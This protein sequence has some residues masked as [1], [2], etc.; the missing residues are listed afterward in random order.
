MPPWTN[1]FMKG[2]T[3]IMFRIGSP[4]LQE[5]QL[6]TN[7]ATLVLEAKK[8]KAVTSI[9]LRVFEKEML[10]HLVLTAITVYVHPQYMGLQANKSPKNS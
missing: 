10:L 6:N 8:W 3:T 2:A 5:Y 1:E 4:V 9:K 7:G